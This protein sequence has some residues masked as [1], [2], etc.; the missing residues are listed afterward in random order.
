MFIWRSFG[1]VMPS[2]LHHL[3]EK[4]ATSDVGVSVH[5]DE[6]RGIAHASGRL[7]SLLE[8]GGAVAPRVPVETCHVDAVGVA[9][10]PAWRA[11]GGEGSFVPAVRLKSEEAIAA[12]KR[13]DGL[14]LDKY[15]IGDQFLPESMTAAMK[16]VLGEDDP[17]KRAALMSALL[18]QLTPENAKPM[19]GWTRSLCQDD[20]KPMSRQ[21]RSRSQDECKADVTAT[22]KPMPRRHS[23]AHT[24]NGS[25][26]EHKHIDAKWKH[27]VR[28]V[29]SL[30]AVIT[31]PPSISIAHDSITH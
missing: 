8:E 4:G 28:H 12:A 2:F 1:D 14:F 15:V 5:T 9:S 30:F 25:K 6:V 29:L 20:A 31:S 24:L 13:V 3:E 22:V 27:T 16:E 7:S 26:H 11:S 10:A 17:L 19:S 23:H 21:M 18:A